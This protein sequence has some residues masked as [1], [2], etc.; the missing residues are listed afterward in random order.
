MR[1]LLGR[2]RRRDP[3]QCRARNARRPHATCRAGAPDRGRRSVAWSACSSTC[4]ARRCAP[5]PSSTTRSQLETGSELTLTSTAVV[6]D[7]QPRSRPRCRSWVNGSGPVTR[8]TSPTARSCCASTGSS[9]ATSCARSCGAACSDRA[10]A[11]TC[12]APNH[13]SSRS[14]IPTPPCSGWPSRSRPTSSGCRS[15]GDRR[16]SRDPRPS[17]QARPPADARREDRD[18]GGARP[19]ARHRRRRRRGDGRP[20]RSR[21]PGSGPPRAAD[22]KGD[23]PV[24]QHGREA[25]DHRHPDARVDDPLAAADPGRGQRRGE[26]G[27]RRHRRARCSRRRRPSASIRP[28][29]CAP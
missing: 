11:C 12:R 17:P 22:P 20:R 5:D 21:H 13:T 19:S 16:R 29:P 15:Y 28:T 23:H 8:S 25:R 9:T 10:K 27:A 14:P 4:P 3:T 26:R 18:R 1:A 24:L 6:G 7:T 2:R